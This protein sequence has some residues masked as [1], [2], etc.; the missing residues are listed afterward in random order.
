MYLRNVRSRRREGKDGAG[1][2]G[3]ERL[4]T[5]LSLRS[6]LGVLGMR[7][8]LVGDSRGILEAS[9]GASSSSTSRGILEVSESSL[10]SDSRG[11]LV[12][13]EAA[14]GVRIVV[15]WW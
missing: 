1:A 2:A 6:R 15:G 5:R 7:E 12:G 3:A 11:I 8:G 4:R 13:C 9:E 14:G 10:V